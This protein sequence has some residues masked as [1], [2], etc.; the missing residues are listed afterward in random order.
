MFR[1]YLCTC[2]RVYLFT[3]FRFFSFR[4]GRRE[5]HEHPGEEQTE[6]SSPER[7][8]GE[9]CEGEENARKTRLT[10][11]PKS[12]REQG[13]GHREDGTARLPRERDE[14]RVNC[15]EEGEQERGGAV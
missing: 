8:T 13:E 7:G 15:E 5:L 14:G 1:V 3:C 6:E 11:K 2:V 9:K 4:P 10:A 12:R